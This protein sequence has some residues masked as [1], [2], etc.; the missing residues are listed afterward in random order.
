M[1]A[2]FLQSK[3]REGKKRRKAETKWRE[4][5]CF[6]YPNLESDIISVFY[7]FS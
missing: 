1:T 5:S 7:S 6:V 4:S 2:V 3:G